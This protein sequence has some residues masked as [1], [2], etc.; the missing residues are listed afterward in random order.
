MAPDGHRC[1]R[2]EAADDEAGAVTRYSYLLHGL[3]ID[4]PNQVWAPTS[5][6]SRSGVTSTSCDHRLGEPG[7]AGVALIHTMD[8]SFCV[9]ALEEA[10]TR[11]GRPDIFNADPG[12]QFTSAVFA[13][14]L[15]AAGI[16]ISIDG[17]ERWMDNVLIERLWRSL[18]YE[19][20]YLKGYADGREA[21]AGTAHTRRSAT[22]R[23]CGFWRNGC[24]LD[25][26]GQNVAHMPTAATA[27][28]STPCCMIS[29]GRSGRVS[30]L[31]NRFPWSR[32]RG[33]PQV[34]LGEA[35]VMLPI[36]RSPSSDA[37]L[38][39]NKPAALVLE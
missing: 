8:A 1:A 27:A 25:G 22:A 9:G 12:S 32:M 2:S 33:P 7:G 38:L 37:A 39:D 14:T 13:G 23:Q 24:R 18:K 20:V 15:A 31:E 6:T 3:T 19:D 30:N 5:P 16:R 21:K 26:Q 28:D 17:R 10:L 4:R 29:R 11:F 36:D 35:L 34:A